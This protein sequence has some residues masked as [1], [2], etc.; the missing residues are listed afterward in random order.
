MKIIQRFPNDYEKFCEFKD[1]LSF[2]K[3]LQL[4]DIEC[5]GCLK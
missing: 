3:K 4:I 1:S 2:S 5:Y